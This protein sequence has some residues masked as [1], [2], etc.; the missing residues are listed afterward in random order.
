MN[1]N[2]DWKTTAKELLN[3]KKLLLFASATISIYFLNYFNQPLFHTVVELFAIIIFCGIFIIGWNSRKY[4]QDSF[5]LTIGISSLFIASLDFIHTIIYPGLGIFEGNIL[6]ISI[7]FWIVARFMQ[8]FSILLAFI[9]LNRNV[10]PLLMLFSYFVMTLIFSFLIFFGLFPTTYSENSGLTLFKIVSEYVICGLIAIAILM[11]YLRRKLI[12]SYLGILLITSFIFLIGSEINF[13]LYFDQF[14]FNVVL[15]HIFKI[16]SSFFLYLAIFENGIRN[17]FDTLFKKI[18]D[19]EELLKEKNESLK[20]FNRILYKEI[21]A[22]KEVEKKLKNERNNLINIMDVVTDKI[23]IVDKNYEIQYANPSLIRLNGPIENQKCY[24]Y[25][26]NKGEPC[27]K[28]HLLEVIKGNTF[29]YETKENGI[30]YHYIETAFITN[31]GKICSLIMKRDIT[32]EKESEEKL[33]HF[34]SMISHEIRTPITVLEQSL[35]NLITPERQISVKDRQDL[36]NIVMKNMGILKELIEDL[37]IIAK[38]EEQ[39]YQLEKEN[40]NGSLIRKEIIEPLTP[41]KDS[42]N[43]SFEIDI[44]ENISFFGDLVKIKQVFRI[45]IDNAIKYSKKDGLIK[46]TGKEIFKAE[47]DL[48]RRRGV[49]FQFIDRGIGISEHE[50]PFIFDRFYRSPTVKRIEGTGLGLSIAK[51]LVN[52]HRGSINVES[53]L[54]EGA[55]FS[56]FFPKDAS[57]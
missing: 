51:D 6:N 5:F 9:M 48:K 30:I 35:T 40:L 14:D 32:D 36:K 42:K 2:K 10:N 31:D 13:T 15:G 33:K 20:E 45:L 39:Q 1:N 29:G 22:R 11:V 50:I 52:L 55:T 28:C 7:Q 12:D 46:I 8:A 17:P 19:H 4:Q 41:R 56:I 43:L 37:T 25:L 23:Y 21:K 3:Y 18:K 47:N 53:K 26:F 34:V 27:Q 16:I 24:S 54:R 44:D 49:L 57:K 38:L